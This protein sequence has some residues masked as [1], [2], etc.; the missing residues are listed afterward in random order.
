MDSAPSLR[1]ANLALL[2]H[3]FS[4]DLHIGKVCAK[5]RFVLVRLLG[6]MDYWRY[7]VDE[8]AA[9]AR[10]RNIELA[11]VPGDRFEDSRLD[12]AS[13]LGVEDLRRLWRYFEEGGPDN[14]SACLQF[15]ANRL[16]SKSPAPPPQP[17]APFGFYDR[18]CHETASQAP[19]ALIVF[20]RSIFLASDVAPI[21]AL[22]RS[23]AARGM[24]VT[25]VYVTS[26][27]DPAVEVA[28]RALILRR[29]RSTS[30]STRRLFRR[31]SMKGAAFSTP[32]TRPCCRSCWPA[33]RKS[34]GAVR[35]A[36][37]ARPIL[38]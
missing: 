25:S 9:M 7:G 10:A 13:T 1:L 16:G 28:A 4:V 20:Y 22:T 3:P 21:D 8:L 2:K 31:A 24:N 33:R 23:L 6:G 32:P 27:K 14:L 19:R 26:L 29:R 18:G 5:A 35:P 30:F 11:I 17:V 34:N 15:I 37:L 36:A 12:A 38:R